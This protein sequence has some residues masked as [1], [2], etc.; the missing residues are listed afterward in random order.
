MHLKHHSLV[1]AVAVILSGCAAP[2]VRQ[3]PLNE[4]AIVSLKQ[5]VTTEAEC[6]AKLGQPGKRE[7]L[8]DGQRMLCY[9]DPGARKPRFMA[10]FGKDGKLKSYAYIP[11]G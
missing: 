4:G 1:V 9:Y 7:T 5:N 2:A 11:R 10:I 3:A 6:V 8:A